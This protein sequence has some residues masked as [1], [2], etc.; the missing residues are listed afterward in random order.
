VTDTA[1][2]D[3]RRI[4]ELAAAHAAVA[5]AQDRAYWLD[6]WGVDLNALMRRR[7]AR[8]LR[9]ALRIAR[10]LKRETVRLKRRTRP[11]LEKVRAEDAEVTASEPAPGRE[12][13]PQPLTASPVTDALYALLTQEDV[14]AVEADA[15]AAQRELLEGAAPVDR[16]RLLLHLGVHQENPGVLERTG[17]TTPMPPEGVH[18]MASGPAAAG[19][20][21]YY[22]DLVVDALEAAG[23]PLEEGMSVLDF[24]CSSGR[25]VRVLSATHRGCR[26]LGCDPIPE[27]IEWAAGHI[28][29][30][31]FERSPQHPPLPLPDGSLH[32]VYAISIW[33]HF[34]A[35]SAREWLAEMRR[36]LEPGGKLL[37]TTHGAHSVEH[38]RANRLRDEATLIEVSRALEREGHWYR[39]EFGETGD[40]G[41]VDPDWG[42]AFLS[43]EWL[44]REATPEWSVLLFASGRVEDNQDLY[45]LERRP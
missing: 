1:E 39:N 37:M 41:V 17:L 25:V 12:L 26:W 44:L 45:V 21:L 10:A 19:G 16:R 30:V 43:P 28:D 23:A 32:V 18:S 31:E 27:A 24:G 33:S 5:A 40:H 35:R 7:G 14:R 15:D 22:A 13:P 2:I 4:E 34:A 29:G 3:R 11:A 42:T 20:S 6:R 38:S 36:V 9:M 8:R